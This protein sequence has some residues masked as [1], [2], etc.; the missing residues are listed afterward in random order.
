[1]R[2]VRDDEG[3]P[4]GRVPVGARGALRRLIAERVAFWSGTA[5]EDVPM[6]LPLAELGMSSRDA[7][8]LAGELSRATGLELPATLLWEATTGDALV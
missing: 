7:V 8:V 2:V 1:M 4:R 3:G 5:A 6:D